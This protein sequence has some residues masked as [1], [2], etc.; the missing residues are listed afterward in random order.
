MN[1]LIT[2]DQASCEPMLARAIGVLEQAHPG[3][4]W[5]VAGPAVECRKSWVVPLGE[6]GDRAEQG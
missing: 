5:G 2:P 6:R 4:R 1:A 3:S